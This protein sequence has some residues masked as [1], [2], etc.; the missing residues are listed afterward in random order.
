MVLL[1]AGVQYV[2]VATT[3]NNLYKINAK[4]GEVVKSRNIGV[5]FMATELGGEFESAILLSLKTDGV[6]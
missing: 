6:T 3:Q 2:F 1:R 4:S 5:P